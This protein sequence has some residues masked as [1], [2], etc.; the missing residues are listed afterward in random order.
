MWDHRLN[1]IYRYS[2][3]RK[4]VMWQLGVERERGQQYSPFLIA[5]IVVSTTCTKW[6]CK[7]YSHFLSHFGTHLKFKL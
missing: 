5:T 2:T 4:D 1:K 6:I 3:A 7:K